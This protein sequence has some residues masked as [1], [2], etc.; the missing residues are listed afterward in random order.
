MIADLKPD[1]AMKDYG[2]SWL[3]RVARHW[4][5]RSIALLLCA[6]HISH[7]TVEGTSD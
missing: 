4:E 7:H 6:P 3:G 5:T 1:S 2:E